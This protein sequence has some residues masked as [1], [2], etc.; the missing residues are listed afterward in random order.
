MNHPSPDAIREAMDRLEAVVKLH[1]H[2]IIDM[3]VGDVRK[4]YRANGD[5]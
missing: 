4:R 1:E 5:C 3:D 2:P